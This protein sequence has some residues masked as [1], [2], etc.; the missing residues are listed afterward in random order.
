MLSKT[1]TIAV[2]AGATQAINTEGAAYSASMPCARCVY[3]DYKWCI[4][5]ANYYSSASGAVAT[6][7]CVELSTS[8]S[9]DSSL[10]VFNNKDFE[11]AACQQDSDQCGTT[12]TFDLATSSDTASVVVGATLTQYTKC[13]YVVKSTAGPIM[14][15]Y[16]GD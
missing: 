7:K 14:Y 2:L 12:I 8:C 3:N 6:D 1:A 11:L 16:T 15:Q 9:T 13:S 5:A 10:R 4:D